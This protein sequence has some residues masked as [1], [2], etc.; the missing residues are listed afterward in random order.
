MLSSI[1]LR[2][3]FRTVLVKQEALG[4]KTQFMKHGHGV[5]NTEPPVLGIQRPTLKWSMKSIVVYKFRI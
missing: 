4:L 3:V 1:F 2:T 5:L